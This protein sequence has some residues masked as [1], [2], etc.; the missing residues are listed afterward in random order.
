MN[1]GKLHEPAVLSALESIPYVKSLFEVDVVSIGRTRYLAFSSDDF[2]WIHAKSLNYLNE[3]PS[4]ITL[5]TV[6][7]D[8]IVFSALEIKT[9]FAAARVGVMMHPSFELIRCGF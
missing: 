1:P 8:T 3:D 2:A 9:R 7:I 5:I 4:S 6:G